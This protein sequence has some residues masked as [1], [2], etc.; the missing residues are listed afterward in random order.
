M[1]DFALIGHRFNKFT[2]SID[3]FRLKIFAQAIGERNPVY[4]DEAAAKNA[5]Y[6]DIL[7]PL[8]FIYC[9]N[10]DQPDPSAAITLFGLKVQH[11]LHA[12]QEI[13]PYRLLFAGEKLTGQMSIADA[14]EKKG[15]QLKFIVCDTAFR[16]SSDEIVARLVSTLVV[17][18]E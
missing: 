16:D 18:D 12:E 15:G 4:F 6:P 5:G 11:V 13:V 3:A 8:T 17:R 10:D 14:F 1:L 2:V 9:L 7:A